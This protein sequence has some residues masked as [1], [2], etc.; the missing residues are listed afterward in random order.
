MASDPKTRNNV[1]VLGKPDSAQAIVFVH[2]FG[3]DQ[4]AWRAVAE[5]FMRDFKIVLL[6][7]VGA[8]RSDPTAFVQHRYLNLSRYAEDLI[9]VCQA[10]QLSNITV[11][12]HSAGAMIAVLA[13]NRAPDLFSRV[14]LI[15]ASPRYLNDVDYFGGFEKPDIDAVY[16]SVTLNYPAWAQSYGGTMIGRMA[17]DH[18]HRTFVESIR[19][20]P[21]DRALTVLCSILQSDHREAVRAL[22]KPTLIIQTRL[23]L[24]VPQ[25]V[26]DF[27][28]ASI[29]NS[30]LVVI[31]TEGHLPHITAAPA[32]VEAMRP[33]LSDSQA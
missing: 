31:D 32:V 12:G 7:N 15:G 3:T 1:S 13:A 24:A 25:Q 18:E 9:E 23:D 6:D 28:N 14:V 5:P 26:A 8:G 20:L 29:L 17:T 4:S 19:A 10:L 16:A 22:S 30:R 21:A 11:V 27:L 2:G 33:F